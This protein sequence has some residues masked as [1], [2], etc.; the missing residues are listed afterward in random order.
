MDKKILTTY[1]RMQWLKGIAE[2][3]IPKVGQHNAIQSKPLP[4]RSYD[5]NHV[6]LERFFLKYQQNSVTA[7]IRWL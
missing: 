2:F 7:H 1:E 6:N 4:I 3:K 5:M